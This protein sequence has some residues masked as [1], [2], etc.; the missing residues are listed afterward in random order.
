MTETSPTPGPRARKPERGAT[1]R[2]VAGAA[3]VSIATASYAFNRIDRIAPPT[4]ERVLAAA[5]ELGYAGPD[6]QARALRRGAVATVSVLGQEGT[7]ELWARPTAALFCQGVATACD[8]TGVALNLAGD[9]VQASGPTLAFRPRPD[10]ELTSS[11]LITIDGEIHGYP[12]ITADIELAAHELAVHLWDLGHRR[13]AVIGWEGETERATQ[14]ARAWRS[15]GPLVAVRPPGLARGDGEVAAVAALQEDP[16]IT[17]IVAVADELALGAIDGVA[18]LGR[19]VPTDVSVAGIDDVP[20]AR[21]RGLTT[22]FVPYEQM[23]Q[24]AT[25]VLL[26]GSAVPPP[27]PAPLTIRSTTGRATP[28][29]SG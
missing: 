22:A 10:G 15:R 20:E 6:P 29:A 4:R 2:D 17:A 9:V 16:G 24:L 12:S 26:S 28:S 11:R 5:R 7:A 14:V 21:L 27:F 1:L 3:G 8:R 23:G 19:S 25:T 18:R 13:L